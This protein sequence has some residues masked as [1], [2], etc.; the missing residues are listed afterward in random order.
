LLPV[1]ALISA[2]DHS[3]IEVSIQDDSIWTMTR[4]L[5]FTTALGLLVAAPPLSVRRRVCLHLTQ[6]EQGMEKNF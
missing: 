6:V 2:A 5:A 4:L 3:E 1:A